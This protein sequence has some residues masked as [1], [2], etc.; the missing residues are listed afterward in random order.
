MNERF[1]EVHLAG[2]AKDFITHL[3][4]LRGSLTEP[5]R[6]DAIVIG[7]EP[8]ALDASH[9]WGQTYMALEELVELYLRAR[10]FQYALIVVVSTAETPERD[11]RW[12][13]ADLVEGAT[14]FSRNVL[15]RDLTSIGVLT[16]PSEVPLVAQRAHAFMRQPVHLGDGTT[17]TARQLQRTSIRNVI[18]E[19]NL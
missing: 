9:G 1:P 12:L 18:F 19:A 3:Q 8:S 13:I 15:G 4:Q 14:V 10:P 2:N 11:M 6:D 5:L 7:L 16:L 17:I